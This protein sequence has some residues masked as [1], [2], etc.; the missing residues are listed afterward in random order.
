[1]VIGFTG[2][3]NRSANKESLLRFELRYPGATWVHGGAEGFDTQ[4]QET[5]LE[6]G[7]VLGETIIVIYPDYDA[8]PPNV[9]PLKRNELIV[10]KAQLLIACYDGRK[11]GGTFYTINYARRQGIPVEIVIPTATIIHVESPD[12][13]NRNQA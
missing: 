8:Y 4:V 13:L 6:L 11:R 10:D 2:H 7:K 3:R 1:M 9:A 12:L 5:A